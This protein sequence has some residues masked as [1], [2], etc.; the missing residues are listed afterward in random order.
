MKKISQLLLLNFLLVCF[1]S[2]TSKFSADDIIGQWK[3]A[4]GKAVVEI[5][6]QGNKYFGKIIWL[7][8]PN[9]AETG[10]PKTDKKNPNENLRSR[11][12]IGLVN[13][14]DFGFVKEN[15]WEDGKIY[16][17]K[18]GKEY[19]CNMKLSDKNTLQVRGY[20]GISLLGRTETW[21]R[22]K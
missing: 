9:D 7:A 12:L 2:F 5:F 6:K 15:V 10:K 21:T 16:D 14:K 3:T 17:P 4:Q 18:N 11:P 1:T 20:I 22:N 19:S 8:E 13:L